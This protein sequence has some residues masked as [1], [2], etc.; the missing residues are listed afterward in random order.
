MISVDT[1]VLVRAVLEDDPIQAAQA[2]ALMKKATESK[3][4]FVSSYAL[5]EMVWVLKVNGHARQKI[6]EALFALLDAPGVTV[7]QSDIVLSAIEKYSKGKADFGDYL[8]LAESESFGAH[9]LAS[10]DKALC[11]D[12]PTCFKPH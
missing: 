3:S 10:F 11:K 5:L 2:K 9:R 6:A 7:G 8:I 4:L 1:N 12:T